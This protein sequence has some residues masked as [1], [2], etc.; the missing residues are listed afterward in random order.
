MRKFVIALFVAVNGWLSAPLASAAPVLS[1][2]PSASSIAVGDPLNVSLVISGLDSVGEIVSGFDL[3]VFFDPTV[4]MA[5]G[6]STLFAPWGTGSDVSISQNFVSP[7]HVE[8]RLLATQTDAI[9]DGL[10]GDSFVLS[11]IFF[12]GIADGFSNISYGLDL[13]S[14]RKVTGRDLVALNQITTG[15]CVAV[16]RGECIATVPEPPT[17]LL[18]C[19]AFFA[20]AL[21]LRRRPALRLVAAQS[22]NQ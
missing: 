1:L 2:V 11:F 6:I 18:V 21:A 16:G 20:G 19:L 14:E 17:L 8:V 9:L 12:Q 13:G 3:D 22:L 4:L 7:G 10:Q 5:T 15:V